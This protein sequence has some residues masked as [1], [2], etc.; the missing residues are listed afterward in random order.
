[1]VIQLLNETT[2]LGLSDKQR[3]VCGVKCG[4]KEMRERDLG[5]HREWGMCALEEKLSPNH[6]LWFFT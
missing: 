1:M 5:D 4:V 3:A 6:L 2:L